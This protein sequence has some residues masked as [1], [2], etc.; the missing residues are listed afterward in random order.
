MHASK[1]DSVPYS[2]LPRQTTGVSSKV[3]GSGRTGCCRRSTR[4]QGSMRTTTTFR[5]FRFYS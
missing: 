3:H 4:R 1:K 2:H 5:I